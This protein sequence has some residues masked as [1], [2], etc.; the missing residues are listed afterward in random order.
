MES[1]TVGFVGGGR[2]VSIL[3]GGWTR[4]GALP[5]GIVVSDQNPD[6]LARLQRRYPEV[7]SADPATA[8]ARGIVFLAV[9]PPAIKDVLAQVR[10]G[11]SGEAVLVSLAPK[12][13]IA[14]LSEM[15]DG[16]GRL[17]RVIPNAASIVGRGY[18]PVAFG[19]GLSP[20]D[21]EVLQGLLAPLGECPE[22]E[23]RHL[24][25]YAIVTAMGPTYFWPQLYELRA[26]AESFGLPAQQAMLAID[27]MLWGA[28][29]TMKDSGLSREEVQDLI[30]VKPLAE[31]E[32]TLI[33]A[34]RAKLTGLMEKLRP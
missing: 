1:R 23:E 29:A 17:A 10:V 13:T 33:D 7:Q 18:N 25:A 9:H 6:V 8:A 3:L 31:I 21:R 22:V 16:F 34:Y 19:P 4:A 27:R 26:L 32:P 12:V 24:E 5:E 15:L 14:K 11:F 2:V 30:P 20:A 28:V